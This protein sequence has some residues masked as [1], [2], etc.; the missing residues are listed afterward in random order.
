ML[1]PTDPELLLIGYARGLIVLWNTSGSG[2]AVKTFVANQQLEGLSW[3]GDKGEFVSIH[4]DGSYILWSQVRQT[5]FHSL[6]DLVHRDLLLCIPQDS[7]ECIEPPNNPYG[8]YPCKAFTKVV[9]FKA[10]D[11]ENEDEDINWMLFTGGMARASYGD[12]H[13]VTLMKGDEKHTVF[14][15]TSK[16]QDFTVI[17][18]DNGTPQS[19]L[20]LCEEELVA[21]DL[22]DDK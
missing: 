6:H 7:S 10:K 9:A 4:N 13:T 17:T 8:P 2:T 16:V 22:T 11:E 21:V 1:H 12:K 20:I 3:R 18:R 19:L 5:P 15:L 14:D